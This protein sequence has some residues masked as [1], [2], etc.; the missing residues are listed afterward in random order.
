MPM[1]IPE[2][3]LPSQPADHHQ[4]G[5]RT[6]R[7]RQLSPVSPGVVV[8]IHHLRTCEGPPMGTSTMARVLLRRRR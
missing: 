8:G 4:L 2:Q 6:R 3:T 5:C 7:N 1:P